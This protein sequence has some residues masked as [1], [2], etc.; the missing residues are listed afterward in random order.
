MAEN[1]AVGWMFSQRDIVVL[2]E[3]ADEAVADALH[4]LDAG[5]EDLR[6]DGEAWEVRRCPKAS[7]RSRSLVK[8][9]VKTESAEVGWVPPNYVKLA[10][11]QAAQMPRLVEALEEHDDAKFPPISTL[12]KRN[13]VMVME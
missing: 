7:V 11:N 4:R 2:Y 9:G 13:A 8:A 12:T 5:A 6:D 10:G 1:G 3:H